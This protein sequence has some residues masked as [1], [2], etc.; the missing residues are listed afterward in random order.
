MVAED[1]TEKEF[2]ALRGMLELE[3]AETGET[4]TF[5]A[6]RGFKER[7]KKESARRKEERDKLFSSIGMDH[8]EIETGAPYINSLVRFFKMRERRYR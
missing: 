1:P 2:P 6:R 7:F 3:D 5:S 4:F 8:I